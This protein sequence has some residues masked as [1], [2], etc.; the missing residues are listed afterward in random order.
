MIISEK[1]IIIIQELKFLK[2]LKDLEIYLN[3]ID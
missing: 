3:L 2:T 1:Q